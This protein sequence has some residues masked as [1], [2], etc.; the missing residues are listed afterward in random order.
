MS[1]I[2]PSSPTTLELLD[3]TS[4]SVAERLQLFSQATLLSSTVPDT[5]GDISSNKMEPSYMTMS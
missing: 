2:I 4:G 1:D 5:S 3:E